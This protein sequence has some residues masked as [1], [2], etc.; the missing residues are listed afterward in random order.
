M[1]NPTRVCKLL[2]PFRRSSKA[3]SE[4]MTYAGRDLTGISRRRPNVIARAIARIPGIRR[5]SA[6]AK[7]RLGPLYEDERCLAY[8]FFEGVLAVFGRCGWNR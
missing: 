3:K 2:K 7:R 8:D 4:L 5:T 6:V 1:D